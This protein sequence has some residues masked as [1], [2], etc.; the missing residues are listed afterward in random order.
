MA[1]PKRIAVYGTGGHG[2]EIAS[3]V[4]NGVTAERDSVFVGFVDDNPATIGTRVN[5]AIV[6]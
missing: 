1:T 4:Q 2:R 3:L 6:W 5:G